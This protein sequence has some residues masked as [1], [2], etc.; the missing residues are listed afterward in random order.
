MGEAQYNLGNALWAAG[1]LDDALSAFE[2]AAES[3]PSS[4]K[5]YNNRGGVLYDQGKFEEAIVFYERALELHER[6]N[7]KPLYT[8]SPLM[9][10]DAASTAARPELIEVNL[11]RALARQGE[12]ERSIEHYRRALELDPA[13]PGAHGGLGLVLAQKGE[14][15]QGIQELEKAIQ[16]DPGYASA[17]LNLAGILAYQGQ[18]DRAARHY[19]AALA[20]GDAAARQAAADGLARLEGVTP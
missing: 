15:D 6:E 1:R 18:D 17:H 5:V 19:R 14:V 16:L 10:G 4:S 8:A 3:L 2:R 13:S 7:P 9:P 11:A 20:S 12:T